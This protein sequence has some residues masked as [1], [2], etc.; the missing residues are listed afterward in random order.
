DLGKQVDQHTPA[1]PAF[2]Q[3]TATMK[4]LTLAKYGIGTRTI[5]ATRK[6]EEKFPSKQPSE[7]SRS[8]QRD[9]HRNRSGRTE[10]L[11]PRREGRREGD[12]DCSFVVVRDKPSSLV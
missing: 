5:T 1:L 3:T 10:T 12:G 6:K 7:N 8:P 2:A 9:R 11:T 4:D